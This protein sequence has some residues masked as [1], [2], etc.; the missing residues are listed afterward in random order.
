VEI[1]K[2]TG[3]KMIGIIILTHGDF[4]RGIKESC[5]MIVGPQNDIATIP[6]IDKGID[7]F[8]TKVIKI[9]DDFREKY[10]Y[11]FILTDFK[12]ATPYNEA[13]RYIL[14]NNDKKFFLISGVNLPLLIELVL[15]KPYLEKIDVFIQELINT[16]R[17]A[18]E[19]SECKFNEGE[20]KEQDE[21]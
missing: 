8:H 20:V 19:F 12:N 21:L 9:M 15:R 1:I 14:A 7:N 16:G 6:L 11:V 18:I 5:E 2:E 4:C 17:S 13:Y 10:Q 3:F